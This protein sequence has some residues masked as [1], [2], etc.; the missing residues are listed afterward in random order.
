MRGI[1]LAI[2]LR[3]IVRLL[4]VLLVLLLAGSAIRTLRRR[5]SGGRSGQVFSHYDKESRK[6]MIPER[7]SVDR[8]K[9]REKGGRIGFAGRVKLFGR[10][11]VVDTTEGGL[12]TKRALRSSRSQKLELEGGE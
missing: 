2:V 11:V 5:E 6:T 7:Q 3:R 8:G 4:L 10:K 12:A 9:Q 1:G